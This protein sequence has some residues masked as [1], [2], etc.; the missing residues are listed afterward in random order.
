MLRGSHTATIDSKGRLKIPTAFKV[1]LEENYSAEFYITSLNGD[2]VRIYPF[3]GWREI[4]EKVASLPSFDKTKKKF[5]NRTS[6]FGQMV[7]MDTQGRILIPSR[8]RQT[9][10]MRG[11]VAVLGCLTYL[12]V[13]NQARF[14]EQIEEDPM[15]PD[16][17][18]SLSM[19][20]L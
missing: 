12:D 10:G 15:T 13:W 5:L 17:E 11:E 9:A 6:Y 3:S 16:D 14:R 18:Q 19:L 1:V 4:E 2:Y 8:L 20:G 7:K